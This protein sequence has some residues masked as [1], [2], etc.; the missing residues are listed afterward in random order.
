VSSLGGSKDYRQMFDEVDSLVAPSSTKLSADAQTPATAAP[1]ASVL[2]L[3]S[4][5]Q[6]S[7]AGAMADSSCFALRSRSRR[8]PPQVAE[9]VELVQLVKARKVTTGNTFRLRVRWK[10][11]ATTSIVSLTDVLCSPPPG[12]GQ[13]GRLPRVLVGWIEDAVSMAGN[14]EAR[15]WAAQGQPAPAEPDCSA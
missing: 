2:N 13:P 15:W 6:K 7:P 10:D 12:P 1:P 11:R 4:P 5:L 8:A 3:Y 14:L 9:V